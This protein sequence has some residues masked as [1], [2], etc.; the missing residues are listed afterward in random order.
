MEPSREQDEVIFDGAT[1]AEASTAALSVATH[2]PNQ[3]AAPQRPTTPRPL[4]PSGTA[5][6]DPTPDSRPL[7]IPPDWPIPETWALEL[8]AFSGAALVGATG[9]ESWA[10]VARWYDESHGGDEGPAG[11]LRQIANTD[12]AALGRLVGRYIAA[13]SEPE[14]PQLGQ[15]VELVNHPE[16]DELREQLATVVPKSD[17]NLEAV[18]ILRSAGDRTR[19]FAAALGTERFRRFT[20]LLEDRFDLGDASVAQQLHAFLDRESYRILRSPA[21]ADAFNA[22]LGAG[23]PASEL[24]D[25]WDVTALTALASSETDLESM[26]ESERVARARELSGFYQTIENEFGGAVANALPLSDLAGQTDASLSALLDRHTELE[27]TFGLSVTT[28][29]EFSRLVRHSP[30][31]EAFFA[32]PENGSR[33]AEFRREF[34]DEFANMNGSLGRALATMSFVRD[35]AENPFDSVAE[36][37]SF[38]NRF[39]RSLA[40]RSSELVRQLAEIDAPALI[41]DEEFLSFWQDLQTTDAYSAN[42]RHA[43]LIPMVVDSYHARAEM[44]ALNSTL[45]AL[46]AEGGNS[47]LSSAFIN[48]RLAVLRAIESSGVDL[49]MNDPD[50]LFRAASVYG[51]R[52][53]TDEDYAEAA[54]TLSE[55]EATRAL[56]HELRDGWGLDP[57]TVGDLLTVAASEHHSGVFDPEV[58]DTLDTLYTLYPEIGRPQDATELVQALSFV[59]TDAPRFLDEDT[60][61]VI[62]RFL[63]APELENY[64]ADMPSGGYPITGLSGRFNFPWVG[65]PN[66]SRIVQELETLGFS[67]EQIS[68]TL[69]GLNNE[70]ELLRYLDDPDARASFF[71]IHT[72]GDRTGLTPR[73]TLEL[74]EAANEV[75]ALFTAMEGLAFL[76]FDVTAPNMVAE[77]EHYARQ[78]EILALVGDPEFQAFFNDTM[79]RLY[80]SQAE[81]RDLDSVRTLGRFFDSTRTEPHLRDVFS[82]DEFRDFQT[83]IGDEFGINAIPVSNLLTAANLATRNPDGLRRV[84][85]RVRRE[86]P[87]VDV[88][89]GDLFLYQHLARDQQLAELFFDRAALEA[90]V[91]AEVYRDDN[92][93]LER[94]IRNGEPLPPEYTERPDP[95]QA[96][97][98]Q[99]IGSLLVSRALE[100]DP[101]F[102]AELEAL[103]ENDIRDTRT[104]RGGYL[105]I[106]ED[107]SLQ[108]SETYSYSEF[109][110]SFRPRDSVL[111]PPGIHVHFHALSDDSAAQG[112]AGPSGSVNGRGDFGY[113]QW[114]D[115]VLAVFTTAGRNDS[116]RLRFNSDV[117]DVVRPFD[118][119][120]T[121]VTIDIGT[122]SF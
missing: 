9:E 105:L 28:P 95:A 98:R 4:D 66:L 1:A 50:D 14:A 80:T 54:G 84:I 63:I 76:G 36:A 41:A 109:D 45:I 83:F 68:D 27:T 6:A 90:A 81:S 71:E 15:L 82:S 74:A 106:A 29:S 85:E 114:V 43:D 57:L 31:I 116:G 86:T 11:I 52:L 34:P 20:D 38:L 56:A 120:D 37:E 96:S 10:A 113:A 5:P 44:A 87:E 49:P 26:S 25:V 3:E 99:L 58:R 24:T 7:D 117:Y 33:L 35:L 23:Y 94:E 60:A 22:M 67:D 115:S 73:A 88:V 79:S 72:F 110:G 55:P 59:A 103:L 61:A 39:G 12:G 62:N 93:A 18:R 78:P 53:F 30:E 2:F 108:L 42:Q 51:S 16:F 75:P 48:E 19:T 122:R 40:T 8:D 17:S 104:E 89:P 119:E 92:A 107:G 111:L 101:A 32:D 121:D 77:A 118:G 91:S 100:K 46:G 21:T 102:L 69:N 70:D 64:G 65:S 47:S 13:A 97:R 112:W